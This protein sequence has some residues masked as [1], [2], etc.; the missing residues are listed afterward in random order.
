MEFDVDDGVVPGLGVLINL[1][2]LFCD[3]TVVSGCVDAGRTKYLSGIP[4]LCWLWI[5]LMSVCPK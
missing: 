5:Q 4:I 3:T 1:H 2:K